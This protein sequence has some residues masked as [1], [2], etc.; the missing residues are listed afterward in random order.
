VNGTPPTLASAATSARHAFLTLGKPTNRDTAN[1]IL[2]W[3]AVRFCIGCLVLL[4]LWWAWEYAR[5]PKVKRRRVTKGRHSKRGKISHRS[6][7]RSVS[8]DSIATKN[9]SL[10]TD[11]PTPPEGIPMTRDTLI[12]T[13][14]SG[15]SPLWHS[16]EE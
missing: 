13:K 9:V 16:E 10:S 2:V 4:A 12:G 8:A 3:L 7:V 11:D 6:N 5:P 14:M 1:T 15:A